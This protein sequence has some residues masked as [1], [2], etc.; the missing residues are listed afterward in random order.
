MP[1]VWYTGLKRPISAVGDCGDFYYA[2]STGN[3]YVKKKVWFITLWC[4]IGN[5]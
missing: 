2:S 3:V 1:N 4:R 5:V